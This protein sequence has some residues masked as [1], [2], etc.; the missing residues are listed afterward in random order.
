M[1]KH[2]L[3]DGFETRRLNFDLLCFDTIWY[4]PTHHDWL[5]QSVLQTHRAER[6]SEQAATRHT[7]RQLIEVRGGAFPEGPCDQRAPPFKWLPGQLW[8]DLPCR[9]VHRF[10]GPRLQDELALLVCLH[11]LHLHGLLSVP[12]WCGCIPSTTATSLRVSHMAHLDTEGELMT[13][14]TGEGVS[15][16][17]L[18]ACCSCYSINTT[19]TSHARRYPW[20][21][22]SRSNITQ[23]TLL[24]VWM[25]LV[26][27]KQH[28]TPLSRL[29][30]AASQTLSGT[31]HTTRQQEVMIFC[32][33]SRAGA[34]WPMRG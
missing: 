6:L 8:S 12:R 15:H 23:H 4:V 22:P 5:W 29:E 20:F 21:I 13:W 18:A 3:V 25:V 32:Q 27:L 26:C 28:L 1:H 14:D 10:S 16:H 9:H 30:S 2:G 7:E 17:S 34:H 31:I 33:T 11:L 24:W 19:I